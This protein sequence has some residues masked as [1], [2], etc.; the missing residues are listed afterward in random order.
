MSDQPSAFGI[1]SFLW[2]ELKTRSLGKSREFFAKVA[3]WSYEDMDMG[4]AG[5]YTMIKASDQSVGG[6]LAMEGPEWGEMPSH[7]SYYVDVEDVDAAAKR[8]L[9]LGGKTL[10]DMV[11]VPGVGKFTPISAPDESSLYL[12]TPAT[13]ATEAPSGAPGTFL[14]VELMSREFS[15][16]KEFYTQL[17]GW[18]SQEMPM[19]EGPYTLF[20][21]KTG[22]AGGGMSMPKSVPE[23]AR[24]FWVGYIHVTDIDAA[25]AAATAAGGQVPVPVEE[26]PG[27]GRFAHIVDPAGAAV[28]LMTPA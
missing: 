20:S 3:G 28:A 15:K 4:P 9:E 17:L 16:A 12:M 19:P 11:E 25:V 18:E 27:V 23:I 10:H 22:G 8:V 24:S 7:W 2:R 1:G 14:W 5:T 6:M 26:V 21:A 13:R